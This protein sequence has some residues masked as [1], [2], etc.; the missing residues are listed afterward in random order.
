M[1]GLVSE[2]ERE[3]TMSTRTKADILATINKINRFGASVS[4]EGVE[5]KNAG[6]A[7]YKVRRNDPG[8]PRYNEQRCPETLSETVN[9]VAEIIGATT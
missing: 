7:G 1:L 3:T 9:L 6:A 2:T 5:I 4:F 8:K